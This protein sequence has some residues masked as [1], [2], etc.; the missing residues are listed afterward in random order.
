MDNFVN[1]NQSIKVVPSLEESLRIIGL[2]VELDNDVRTWFDQIKLT[3]KTW[4]K[5]STIEHSFEQFFKTN[6]DPYRIVL[7]FVIKCKEFKDCKPKTLPFF[8]MECFQKWSSKTGTVPDESL[9]FPAFRI[10]TEQR[11]QLFLNMVIKTYRVNTLKE[12]IIPLVKDMIQNDNSKRA[13]QVIIAMELFEEIPVED[14]LFPLILQDKHNMI[15]EYL[16]ECPTQVL[17]LVLFLD[18]LLNKSFKTR[19]YIQ[20]Y[21]DEFKICHVKYEKIHYKPLGKLVARLCNKYNIPIETCKNLSKNRTLGGLRYL[22]HQKYIDRN[23]SSAVWDDLV[24]D[25]LQQ[26]SE[27]AKE[28]ISVL[29]DY[30]IREAAKWVHYLN[31]PETVLPHSFQKLSLSHTS[32]EENWDN[33]EDVQQKFYQFPLPY[34]KIVIIDTAEKFY[35]LTTEYLKYRSV[36]S[37]DCEWKP[38]FGAS[39]SQVALIQVAVEDNVYLID[40]LI[41]NK[42]KY[43]S[44]WQALNKSLL[45]N[46]E[47]IKLGFGLEQDL[48]EIKASIVGLGNI[49]VKGEGLLDLSILWKNLINSGLIIQSSSSNEGNSLSS[50]V[51]I[52]FG[53]PLQKSEQCSNWEIRPLRNTQIQY[54]ALDA[55]VLLELYNFLQRE[56]LNQGI[57]FEEICNDTMLDTKTKCT[58]KVKSFD[59]YLSCSSNT[60]MRTVGEVKFFVECKLTSLIPYLRHFGIDTEPLSESML[61]HDTINL[62]ISQDRYILLSKLKFSPTENYSQRSILEVSQRLCIQK[63]LKRIKKYFNINIGLSDIANRCINCNKLDFKKL[64]VEEVVDIC[65][66]YHS[67]ECVPSNRNN[68]VYTA[69]CEDDT[70]YDNFLSDSDKDDDICYG[71]VRNLLPNNLCKTSKGIHIKIQNVDK[72]IESPQPAILCES[73]GKLFWDGDEMYK[74]VKNI[75]F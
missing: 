35:D 26:N 72:L 51:K 41:L 75:T 24:K 74:E 70:T 1:C 71:P 28:F 12:T 34:D 31:L 22:I 73:C 20:K 25:S 8:I 6:P 63:Q 67:T 7:V 32:G 4:K 60:P 13:S 14:L 54:A 46:A 47:I 9:K 44:F 29:I 30:D 58:K 49:K 57:N 45:D 42:Q 53:L 48:K 10:A 3:W 56:C 38:S 64:T 69:D 40:T 21:I 37:I 59:A 27:A 62:A 23:V 16:S 66:K 33:D 52:C 19:E 50:L 55:H 15:D 17:R 39:Q 61:W 5:N 36:V 11:N 2:D 18:K 68:Y 65:S 43:C